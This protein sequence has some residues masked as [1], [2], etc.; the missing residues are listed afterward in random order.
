MSDAPRR[1]EIELELLGERRENR[2]AQMSARLA[3]RENHALENRDARVAEDEL[4]GDFV[5]HAEAAA[6]R[7]R[8]EGR[9]ERELPRLE[10]GEREPARRAAVALGEELRRAG[11]VA[12]DVDDAVGQAKRRLERIGEPA[13]ILGASDQAVDDDRDAVVVLLAQL[14]RRRELDRLSIDD[15]AH[16]ALLARHLEEILELALAAAHE[17][18]EHL[19]ARALGPREHGVGDLRRALALHGLAARRAVRSAGARVEQAQVVVDLG[20]GAD[21]RARIVAGGLLLDRDGGRQPLDRVDVRF[22][23][24][25]QELARVRGQRLDVPALPLRVNRV[26]GEGRLPGTRESGDDGESVPRDRYVDI[27]EDCARGH[28]AQSAF[29]RA[30]R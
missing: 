19:D 3:P 26:E 13:A 22:L 29:L 12:H 28:R 11:V 21:G 5:L 23:H 17:R 6:A 2:L 14:G 9:V 1:V 15:R 18:R 4:F 30:S 10:L 7:A 8:A 25:A 20:D 16:E 24:Q 27:S